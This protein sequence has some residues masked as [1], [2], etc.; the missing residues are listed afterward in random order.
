MKLA[1]IIVTIL[2]LLMMS[3][4]DK[5]DAA[6]GALGALY[7]IQAQTIDGE[8]VSLD[9]YRGKVLLIV[10]VASRCGFTSQYAGLQELYEKYKGRGLVVLGFP[11]NDFGGQEPGTESEIKAFCTN[12]YGVSFPMFSKVT[13]LGPTKH[14][15]YRLL[16]AQTG[17]ADVRWNFEKFLIDP[18]GGVVA[19]FGSSTTPTDQALVSALEKALP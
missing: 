5:C 2:G 19:R 8:K 1:R 10:N 7:T 13:V 4:V 17:G 18:A 15:L 11:S 3:G 9:S 14:P 16:T 6:D 12:S